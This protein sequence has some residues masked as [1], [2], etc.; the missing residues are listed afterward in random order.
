MRWPTSI[1]SDEPGRSTRRRKAVLVSVGLVVAL[2]AAAAMSGGGAVAGDSAATRGAGP[3]QDSVTTEVPQPTAAHLEAAGLDKLPVA[4]DERRVDLVAPPFSNPTAVTNP[5]FPISKLHSVV[6]NGRVGGEPFRVETTLLPD[7][8]V[9]EWSP[10][11]CV[12]TL[13]SQYTAYL[14]GRIEEVALDFYAQADD[15]SVWYFGEDVYNYTDGVIAD[16]SG[17]WLAGKEGPA[18]M[19]M[20]ADPKV[21]QVNRPENI[22][23]L[24]FEEV[25]VKEVDRTVAGPRG[26]VRG[27]IV[28]RELHDDGTVSDKVFAPGYGE[29]STAHEGDVEAL[30]LA[31]PT[32]T[33]NAPVPGRLRTLLRGAYG[34]FDAAG[35]RRWTQASA[36]V[37]RMTAAWNAQR[38]AGGVPPRLVS[39][40]SRALGALADAVKAHRSGKARGAALDVALATLD[41]QLRYRRPAAIDRA[42][43]D[44]WARQVLVD[45]AARDPSGVGGDVATLEWVRDR[46]ARTLNSVDVTRIDTL[47]EE[48]RANANDEDFKAAAGTAKILRNALARARPVG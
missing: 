4:P 19:I 34:V 30:A 44:L 27:A 5:L 26:P 40:T 25:A 42:R 14:D 17:T 46:V 28:G 48:L 6:L 21:G 11:Q 24:V 8:R 36:T 43:F 39:P 7:T 22:P 9:I 31:V 16:T 37:A 1:R 23:G 2:V 41:L 35:S 33:L 20:P 45:A 38:A 12:R 3:C 18:A 10:G 13:V 32:D 15:G 47:L 29:F